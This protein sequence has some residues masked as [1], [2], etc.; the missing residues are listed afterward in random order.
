[1]N[2]VLHQPEMGETGKRYV[3]G[4]VRLGDHKGEVDEEPTSLF[5]WK[6]ALELGELAVSCRGSDLHCPVATEGVGG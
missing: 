5:V 6:K 2:I 4:L 1:M 3:H